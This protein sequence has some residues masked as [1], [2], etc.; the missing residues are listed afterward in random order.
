MEK[1]NSPLTEEEKKE[2]E[3]LDN[4]NI[5]YLGSPYSPFVTSFFNKKKRKKRIVKLRVKERLHELLI[6]PDVSY[7]KYYKILEEEEERFDKRFEDEIN[8]KKDK[9]DSINKTR[10]M[11]NKE[12][13]ISILIAFFPATIISAIF[14]TMGYKLGF[15][16]DWILIFI[17]AWWITDIRRKHKTK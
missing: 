13:I 8:P 14:R 6:D 7:Q 5:E 16:L 4:P 10:R 1:N 2:L 12:W 17:I 3:V 15:I 11:S 9:K